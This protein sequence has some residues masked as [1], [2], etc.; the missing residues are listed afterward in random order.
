MSKQVIR[1]ENIPEIAAVVEEMDILE[2]RAHERLRFI[3]KQRDAVM[4]DVQKQGD[5]CWSRIKAIIKEQKLLPMGDYSLVVDRDVS[6]IR[7]VLPSH[8]TSALAH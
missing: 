7:V 1:Y 8:Q 3:N 6:A 5:E 4:T 2:T